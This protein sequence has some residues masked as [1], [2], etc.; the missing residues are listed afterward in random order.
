MKYLPF[1]YPL[2]LCHFMIP[3]PM[4]A[5]NCDITHK[6]FSIHNSTS[7]CLSLLA[8]SP[9]LSGSSLPHTPRTSWTVPSLLCCISGRHLLILTP[10]DLKFVSWR[11]FFEDPTGLLSST[12]EVE[13]T[14]FSWL[15]LTEQSSDLTWAWLLGCLPWEEHWA[16]EQSKLWMAECTLTTSKEAEVV[17][18]PGRL[19]W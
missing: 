16:A 7:R 9:V 11:N 6:S 2:S 15:L 4:I 3:V 19:Q 10:V 18:V 12:P 5:S 14:G 13:P 17:R 8:P 1:L